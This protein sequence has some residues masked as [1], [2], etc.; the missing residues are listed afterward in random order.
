MVRGDY[1]YSLDY[2]SGYQDSSYFPDVTGGTHQVYVKDLNGCG[3]VG[4]VEI[5]VLSVPKFFTP[6][7]DGYNDTWNIKG[8]TEKLQRQHDDLCV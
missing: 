5:Y 1:V 2:D 4:P 7:G 8:V 3:T 6:N